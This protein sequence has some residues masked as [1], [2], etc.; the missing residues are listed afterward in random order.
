MKTAIAAL[1][2]SVATF[3]LPTGA[4]AADLDPPIVTTGPAG[5]LYMAARAGA[6]WAEETDFN[7]GALGIASV[8]NDYEPG[9]LGILAVGYDFANG[10]RGELE[11]S[12]S[13]YDIDTHSASLIA[14]GVTP[15]PSSQSFGDAESFAVMASAYYDIDLGGIDPFIGGGLGWGRV[16]ADGFGVSPLIGAL[17]GGVALDDSDSGLAYHIT[18]GLSF[19]ITDS[20]KAEVGYRYQGINADLASV[21]GASR[22]FDLTSH[23]AFVGLRVGF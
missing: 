10:F 2:L 7:V 5:G 11:L 21:T 8:E 14:G 4:M 12:Y 6:S 13:K 23:N 17:P 16:E 18:A 22:S 3:A 19:D 15:F 1:S 9:F 20:L